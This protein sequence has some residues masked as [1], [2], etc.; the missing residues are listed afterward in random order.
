MLGLPNALYY[1]LPRDQVA[2]RGLILDN[3]ALLLGGAVLFSLFILCGGYHLLAMRFENPDLRGS[4]PWLAPYPL[5]VMPIAGLAAVLVI[6]DR[7]RLLAVYNMLSSLALTVAGIIA[8]LSTR[9]YMAPVLVRIAVSAILLPVAV[10]LLF[11][12]IPGALRWPNIASMSAMLKYSV[13]LGLASMLG[14]ITLQ[15]HSIIVASLCSPEEFAV[16]ING[17][18]EIPLI[19]VV[20]GSIT[21]VVFAEMA[22]LCA[23]GDR[24]AAL[25][26]FQD[27]SLRSACILFPT[28]CFLIVAAHPFI[29][30]LYS[31]Q[32]K[33]SALP[34]LIYLFVLPVRVVVYGA[35]LMALGMTRVVLVRSSLDLL[36][37]GVLCFV[38]VNTVGYLGAALATVLTLYAWTIPYN[39]VK[40][41]Q[42][43]DVS[44]RKVLPF[45][46]LARI[47][48]VCVVGMPLAAVGVYAIPG[49]PLSRLCLAAILYGP[50]VAYLLYRMSFL[51]VPIW[52]QARI[53]A[54]L[55]VRA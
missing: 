45:G 12:F 43:F 21:T 54:S 28:M 13:P 41:G 3:M 37:N 23:H 29:L 32:Y 50:M 46:G 24:P 53:P 9:S 15:L 33:D 8:V 17:A 25:R 27:A 44:W 26:L 16:Y 22:E 47:L 1:F 4:L 48:A 35:A 38:L 7:T 52:V 10:L 20:T 18:M 36:V 11:R 51:H 2:K 5:L 6:A 31:E 14:S 40:I 30:V 34:F 55:R 42:G 19:G 39:L 49:I